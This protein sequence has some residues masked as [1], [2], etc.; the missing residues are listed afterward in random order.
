MR[1][2]Y[3]DEAVTIYH[4]DARG[5]IPEMGQ[6]E[7]VVSDPPY[8]IDYQSTQR[9]DWNRKPKISGDHEFPLWIFEAL[10]PTIA[11]LIFCRWD[12]LVSLPLPKSFIV[13]DKG[14]H[15]MGDLQ[16]EYGR[17]W[18]GCAF[19]PGALHY[20]LYRPGDLIQES[21]S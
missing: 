3:K 11:M 16:H 10:R 2:Y 17:R 8:G 4:G 12:I 18:E 1:P 20:F 6:P 21:G 9:T 14:N 5:I 19:Y 13:W 7:I 15:S